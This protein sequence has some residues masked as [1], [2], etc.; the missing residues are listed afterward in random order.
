MMMMMI[1]PIYL[2]KKIRKKNYSIGFCW[3]KTQHCMMGPAGN[4]IYCNWVL[5]AAGP[6]DLAA[7][8]YL[9]IAKTTPLGSYYNAKPI[10]LESGPIIIIFII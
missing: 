2:V 3:G 9:Q 4:R 5:V 1:F 8:F 6:N 10:R 7:F